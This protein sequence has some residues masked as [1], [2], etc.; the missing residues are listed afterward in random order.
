MGPQCVTLRMALEASRALLQSCSLLAAQPWL[1][2]F[3]RLHWG[4]K[5]GVLTQISLL[6]PWSHFSFQSLG[7][8]GNPPRNGSYS[9]DLSSKWR[10]FPTVRGLP[11]DVVVPQS[12]AVFEL[13]SDD[14][15]WEVLV[16]GRD[17]V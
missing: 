11:W 17:W 16:V 12:P 3:V 5:V 9:E 15:L 7:L 2:P 14:H 6:L 10:N 13:K 4:M 8:S 1:W